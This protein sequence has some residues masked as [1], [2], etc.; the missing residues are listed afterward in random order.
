MGGDAKSP[1]PKYDDEGR[2]AGRVK[3]DD[4]P[5]ENR[6]GPP[7]PDAEQRPGYHPKW[8]PF[9]TAPATGDEHL[10][11]LRASHLTALAAQ[12]GLEYGA[13]KGGPGLAELA[14]RNARPRM[15]K[16]TVDLR[17]VAGL[18]ALALL[19]GLYSHG[20]LR[21]GARRSRSHSRFLVL[22][23]STGVSR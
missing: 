8:A 10:S 1:I 14:A 15:V 16:G 9:G 3:A 18:A 7:P 11:S 21:T 17:P 13:V 2:E 19:A 6:T 5:Q 20:L 23:L 22:N 12:T 4:V